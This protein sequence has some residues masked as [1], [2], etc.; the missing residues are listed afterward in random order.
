MVFIIDFIIEF[1][2]NPVLECRQGLT[3]IM[4]HFLNVSINKIIVNTL[5]VS[6]ILAHSLIALLLRLNLLRDIHSF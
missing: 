5:I 6:I 4:K 1:K 3:F 2:R